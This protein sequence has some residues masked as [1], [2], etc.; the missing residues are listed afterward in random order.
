VFENKALRKIFGTKMD[1]V[2]GEWKKLH[3]ELN[4]VLLT[5]YCASDKIGKNEMGWTCNADGGKV[6]AGF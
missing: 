2:T 6:C 3:N 4:A 1:E 5:Q